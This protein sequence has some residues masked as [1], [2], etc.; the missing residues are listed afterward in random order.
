M[1]DHVAVMNRGVFE[2]VDTPQNLYNRPDTP[3]VAQFVGDNNTWSGRIRQCDQNAAEIETAEGRVFRT[4][5]RQQFQTGDKV[6]L[7]LRPEA[8]L[9]QPD[10]SLAKL[11]RFE[12]V[13][14]DLLFDGANS[15]L[16][17]NPLDADTELLIALPQ[18]RQY[19][20]IRKNDKIEIGWDEQSGICFPRKGQ[21][22][23]VHGSAF[24]G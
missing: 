16:L 6:D 23:K 22:S 13:V 4:R 15:R 1:S 10:A 24:K 7:F 17:A 9:I 20:Y 12:V 5:I 18:T 3:F 2:Q 19:D 8:M 11:N 14:K 21:G